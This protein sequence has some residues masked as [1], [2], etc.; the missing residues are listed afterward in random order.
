MIVGNHNNVCEYDGAYKC[1]DCKATWGALMDA[2]RDPPIECKQTTPPT[3][4]SAPDADREAMAMALIER[5][6]THQLAGDKMSLIEAFEHGFEAALLHARKNAVP[7][8]IV[9]DNAELGVKIGDQFFWLYKGDNI[10]YE[11]ATHDDGTPMMWRIVGKREFGECCHPVKF[12]KDGARLPERYTDTLLFTPGLSFG[13][14]DDGEWRPL[15]P[16]KE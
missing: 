11:D 7:E 15:P 2:P 3:K 14:P 9:N 1:L 8:W 6:G 5:L 13:N 10:V 12:Y 4:E 16:T